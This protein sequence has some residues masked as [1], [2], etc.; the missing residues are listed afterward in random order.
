MTTPWLPW[1]FHDFWRL[2]EFSKL[3][4]VQARVCCQH[5]THDWKFSGWSYLATTPEERITWECCRDSDRL[6]TGLYNMSRKE[7]TRLEKNSSALKWGKSTNYTQSGTK[8]LDRDF[9]T[10]FIKI[11]WKL[12]EVWSLKV[13]FAQC[14]E[15]RRLDP[16]WTGEGGIY[17]PRG[18]L[19]NISNTV[20]P[21]FTKLCDF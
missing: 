3:Q 18:F 15:T 1:Q 19:L 2:Q 8:N 13:K 9:D 17:A 12:A 4:I 10:S 21:I 16:I 14:S 11:G 5:A 6:N 7:W 20:S